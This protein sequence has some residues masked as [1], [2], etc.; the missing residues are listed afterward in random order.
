MVQISVVI[1][2]ICATEVETP[3]YYG[4]LPKDE[5]GESC[6]AQFN[7]SS[8]VGILFY[9]QNNC[10]IEITFVVS[11]YAHYTYCPKLSHEKTLN[12]LGDI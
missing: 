2:L 7:Y 4:A 12:K 9:L 11:Q 1:D 3:V 5:D 8:I 6:D 10:R